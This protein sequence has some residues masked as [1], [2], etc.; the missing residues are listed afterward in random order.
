MSQI[1][2]TTYIYSDTPHCTKIYSWYV[3]IPPY[4]PPSTTA[5]HIGD[6]LPSPEAFP[7]RPCCSD[8]QEEC[9]V[10]ALRWGGVHR[11]HQCHVQRAQ[12]PQAPRAPDKARGRCELWVLA[13]CRCGKG[14]M[15]C[16]GN[17]TAPCVCMCVCVRVC[18]CACACVRTCRDYQHIT[19]VPILFEY[20]SY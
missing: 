17:R 6:D 10:G 2:H 1:W 5:T 7:G 13:P 9:G 3:Y 18:M 8:G 16:H 12:Q 15:V 4:I 20:I 19:V 11:P 14:C